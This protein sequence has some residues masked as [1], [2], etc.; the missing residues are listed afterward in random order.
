MPSNDNHPK[1]EFLPPLEFGSLVMPFYTQALLTLGLIEGPEKGEKDI[2]LDL[3]KRLIDLLD[4][5][6]DKTKG[7]LEE[8]EEKFLEAC[9]SQLKMNYLK[10]AEIIKK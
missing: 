2:N 1:K 10:T 4:V 8:D 3:A 7:N 9:L 6:R 5:L